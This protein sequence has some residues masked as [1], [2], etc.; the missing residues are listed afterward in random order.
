MTSLAIYIVVFVVGL[1]IGYCV[2]ANGSK[3]VEALYETLKKEHDELKEKIR[4]NK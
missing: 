4:K 3:K 1:A 2:R